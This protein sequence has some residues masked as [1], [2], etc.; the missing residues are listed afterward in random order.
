MKLQAWEF[1][2]NICTSAGGGSAVVLGLMYHNWAGIIFGFAAIFVNLLYAWL[3]YKHKE[4]LID[5]WYTETF[6]QGPDFYHAANTNTG[7]GRSH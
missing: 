5:E 2:R 6:A 3:E 1:I 4:T 7:S